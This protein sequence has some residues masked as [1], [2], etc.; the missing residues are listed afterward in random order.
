MVYKVQMGLVTK[1]KHDGYTRK[2]NL[3]AVGLK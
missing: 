1:S 3:F 2:T